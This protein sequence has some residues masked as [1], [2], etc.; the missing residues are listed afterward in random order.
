MDGGLD[1]ADKYANYNQK[2]VA[3]NGSYHSFFPVFSVD[4]RVSSTRERLCIS[5]CACSDQGRFFIGGILY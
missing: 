3:K 4:I 1:N 5:D 2:S